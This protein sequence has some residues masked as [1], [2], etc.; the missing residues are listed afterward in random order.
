MKGKL[1][2]KE[3]ADEYHVILA[4]TKEEAYNLMALIGATGVTSRMDLV[5]GMTRAGAVSLGGVYSRYRHEIDTVY[6]DFCRE[7]KHTGE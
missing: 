1:I 3:T 7:G 6:D 5:T 2:N 4:L